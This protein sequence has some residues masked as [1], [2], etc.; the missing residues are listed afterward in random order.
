MKPFQPGLLHPDRS[1]LDRA[2][3]DIQCPAHADK[4]G[5]AQGIPM[6]CDKLLL[7]G[8]T[9]RDQQNIRLS[10]LNLLHNLRF[11]LRLEEAIAEPDNL[12][13]RIPGPHSGGSLL[14]DPRSR[15]EEEDTPVFLRRKRTASRRQ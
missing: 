13:P 10:G 12:T 3:K 6:T 5:H 2:G 7:L 4:Y 8:N 11:V 9:Q 15:A 1:A 14:R